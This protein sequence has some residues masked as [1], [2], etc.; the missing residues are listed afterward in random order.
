MG[1]EK[2]EQFVKDLKKLDKIR[3]VI[4]GKEVDLRLKGTYRQIKKQYRKLLMTIN[5][6]T[7]NLKL[8][9]GTI[10]EQEAKKAKD[11]VRYL[12]GVYSYID[13]D[14]NKSGKRRR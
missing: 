10:S 7:I 9:N 12:N 6:D 8:K 1:A 3:L 13:E 14:K 2:F 11:A 4:D 5:E